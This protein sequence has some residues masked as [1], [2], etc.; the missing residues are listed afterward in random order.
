MKKMV[1]KR[2]LTICLTGMLVFNTAMLCAENLDVSEKTGS[3]SIPDSIVTGNGAG[4]AVSNPIFEANE[5]STGIIVKT[6][7]NLDS[8]EA[9]LTEFDARIARDPDDATLYIEKAIFQR[10][11][12]DVMGKIHTLEKALK[13]KNLK[14][15]GSELADIHYDLAVLYGPLGIYEKGYYHFLVLHQI[16]RHY[17][18]RA[19][20][21]LE[22]YSEALFR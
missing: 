4:A 7:V 21:G 2:A 1:I 14:A 12:L 11:H 3:G 13:R 15:E 22:K 16:D 8:Y 6:S 10:M 5:T 17:F 9:R 20:A 19:Q 18:Q